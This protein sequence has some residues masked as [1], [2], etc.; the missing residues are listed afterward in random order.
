M[1][2][3]VYL[4]PEGALDGGVAAT[5]AGDSFGCP[6]SLEGLRPTE[7]TPPCQVALKCERGVFSPPTP[8]TEGRG[9][10]LPRRFSGPAAGYARR[11]HLMY[12]G[13]ARTTSPCSVAVVVYVS[14][15]GAFCPSGLAPNAS[16]SSL[17]FRFSRLCVGIGV[18]FGGRGAP[19]NREQSLGLYVA[20]PCLRTS[21]P[22]S[23]V[24]IDVTQHA[25]PRQFRRG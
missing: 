2:G 17:S 9:V 3:R 14:R 25:P 20:L 22:V 21:A 1:K 11:N 7:S 5:R 18:P 24:H 10:A 19:V 8:S 4:A 16:R 12:S 23:E 15:G 13:V 6:A